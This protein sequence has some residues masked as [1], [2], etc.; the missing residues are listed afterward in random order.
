MCQLCP[1]CPSSVSSVQSSREDDLTCVHSLYSKMATWA[2]A[3]RF[4]RCPFLHMR[5]PGQ[6][7]EDDLTCIHFKMATRVCAVRFLFYPTRACAVLLF[8]GHHCVELRSL[9]LVGRGPP[10]SEAR[11]PLGGGSPVWAEVTPPLSLGRPVTS[12]LLLCYRVRTT[13]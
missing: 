11:L 2:C 13:R 10:L 5:S 12:L 6:S 4:L 8:W 1:M 7:N 3:V 9:T